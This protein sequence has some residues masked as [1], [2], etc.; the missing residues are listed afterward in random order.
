[1]GEEKHRDTQTSGQPAAGVEGKEKKL[2]LWGR[3]VKSAGDINTLAKAFAILL[4]ILIFLGA[5]VPEF[6]QRVEGLVRPY[7]W[8]QA[9]RLS[10]PAS[11]PAFSGARPGEA[12]RSMAWDSGLRLD[13]FY[14]LPGKVIR[15]S[16]NAV[17]RDGPSGSNLQVATFGP[18]VC[19]RVVDMSFTPM[20]P[21]SSR[22]LGPPI[23]LS[24]LSGRGSEAHASLIA[25][26]PA[27]VRSVT[28]P[29]CVDEGEAKA[30]VQRGDNPPLRACPR[31]AVWVRAHQVIC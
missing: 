16:G 11:T 25:Q 17:G 15:T 20:D 23:P 21:V 2:G 13:E 28:R 26:L 14:D 1:M 9:V 12:F 6:R 22:A 7:R 18:D 31:I 5:F 3:A 19:L 8:Y 10:D 30:S 29:P 24:A 4:A 27:E